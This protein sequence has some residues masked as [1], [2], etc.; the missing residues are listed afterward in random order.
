MNGSGVRKVML[1]RN[2][3][4]EQVRTGLTPAVKSIVGGLG[5]LLLYD[6]MGWIKCTLGLATMLVR[7]KRGCIKK[8]KPEVDAT[9]GTVWLISTP[10]TSSA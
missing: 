10:T 6:L 1:V 9:V 4:T 2:P 8:R 3:P 5:L 7:R